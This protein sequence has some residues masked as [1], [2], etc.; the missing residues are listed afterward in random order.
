[1]TNVIA[2]TAIATHNKAVIVLVTVVA[3]FFVRLVV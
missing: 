1:M 3:G 2:K